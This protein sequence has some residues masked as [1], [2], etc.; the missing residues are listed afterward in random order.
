MKPIHLQKF[1]IRLLPNTERR[2]W[3]SATHQHNSKMK[4][5]ETQ[6]ATSHTKPNPS[7]KRLYLLR[8]LERKV[9]EEE[10]SWMENRKTLLKTS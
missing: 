8:E 9:G 10:E 4:Y 5:I 7:I 6:S 1:T 3:H 2:K